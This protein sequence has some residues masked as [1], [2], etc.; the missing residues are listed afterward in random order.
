[1]KLWTDLDEIRDEL[2]KLTE[3]DVYEYRTPKG[4][5]S[6]PYII[7][8]EVYD[9]N[10][11]ADNVIYSKGEYISIIVLSSQGQNTKNTKKSKIERKVEDF[12]QSNLIPYS[13]D[14]SYYSELMLFQTEYSAK[15][16][17][18]K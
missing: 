11:M 2:A 5:I 3:V 4:K 9:R 6:D 7:V 12:L 13:R 16:F 17:Y 18:G 14:T 1:M 10:F 8:S 15:V